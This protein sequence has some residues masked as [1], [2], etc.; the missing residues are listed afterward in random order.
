[1]QTAFNPF[2]G[3]FEIVGAGGPADIYRPDLTS[4]T[5]G[6]ASS[7]NGQATLGLPLLMLYH[8]TV[9]NTLAW[10]QLQSGGGGIQPPDYNAETNNVSWVEVG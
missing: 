3:Q 1:M 7:L 10:Y 5:G 8:F 4:A 9:N 6:T 2:T